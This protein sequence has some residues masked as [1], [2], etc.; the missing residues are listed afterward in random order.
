MSGTTLLVR[1]KPGLS[2]AW[3][4]AV[5]ERISGLDGVTEARMAS[6]GSEDL[7]SVTLNGASV[8]TRQAINEIKGVVPSGHG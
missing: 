4:R 1:L 2:I 3:Q 8:E 6:S 5:Q 7:I